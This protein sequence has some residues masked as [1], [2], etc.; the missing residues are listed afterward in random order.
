MHAVY[1]DVFPTLT[2]G[3]LVRSWSVLATVVQLHPVGPL[4]LV[5]RTSRVAQ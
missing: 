3:V 1:Q 5:H 2:D 4:Q